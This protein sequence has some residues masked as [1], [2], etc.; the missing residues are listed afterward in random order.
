[1]SDVLLAGLALMLIFEGVLPFAAPAL[2][3]DTFRRMLAL[4]DGQLRFAGLLSIG[5]GLAI[6]F[7][8]T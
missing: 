2:W 4:S 6:L 7:A 8:V 1:M 3:R 5:A